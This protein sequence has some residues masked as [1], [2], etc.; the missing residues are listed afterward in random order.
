MRVLWRPQVVDGLKQLVYAESVP[1]G[2]A[3]FP[4][5]K[6]VPGTVSRMPAVFS[7]SLPEQV[8]M[9]PPPISTLPVTGTVVSE[10]NGT[11]GTECV[12]GPVTLAPSREHTDKRT[13]SDKHPIAPRAPRRLPR[14]RILYF[15]C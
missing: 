9:F 12:V 1:L 13:T 14:T 3:A 10:A 4:V 7:S 11:S 6:T 8:A 15:P 2:Y 5:V